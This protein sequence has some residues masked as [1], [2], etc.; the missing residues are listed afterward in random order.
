MIS[1]DPA[2]SSPEPIVFAHSRP[3]SGLHYWQRRVFA[4]ILRHYYLLRGSWPRFV[5]MM[6]WPTINMLVWG[7]LN[8]Y[9]MK[10]SP[11][12]FFTAG[13]MIGA[14]V[15]W[16]MFIRSQFGILLPLFEELWSRN[17]GN[18]FVA[19]VSP[20]EYASSLILFGVLRCVLAITPAII[21]AYVFFDYWIPSIGWPFVL[22]VINLMI[23]GWFFGLVLVALILKYGLAAEWIAWM[24]AFLV[25]PVVAV[26]YPVEALPIWLQHVAWALPPTYVFE[27][28]RAIIQHKP[29]VGEYMWKALGLNLIYLA[30][31]GKIYLL[32]FE[33]TRRTKGLLH[34]SD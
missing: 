28:M 14:A 33:N 11:N 13:A 3:M 27:S 17:M 12:M 24:L 22:F 8:G 31:A 1:P 30:L 18:I 26:Y 19:P 25:S 10:N 6:Y 32:V 34:V 16:E 23:A 2:Q 21:L 9:L 7:F 29:L 15:M 5:E 4:N 20:L